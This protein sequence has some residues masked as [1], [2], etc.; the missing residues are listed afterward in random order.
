MLEGGGKKNRKLFLSNQMTNNSRAEYIRL[1]H[2]ILQIS[3]Y[4]TEKIITDI[5]FSLIMRLR[6]FNDKESYKI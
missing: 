3:H 2:I 4:N 5:T 6:V 1:K